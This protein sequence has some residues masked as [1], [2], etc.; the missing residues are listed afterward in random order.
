MLAAI[1]CKCLRCARL[2]EAV[3]QMRAASVCL[4]GPFPE[5][6]ATRG[7]RSSA[8]RRCSGGGWPGACVSGQVAISIASEAEGFAAQRLGASD[9]VATA[10]RQSGQLARTRAGSSR[11]H[12]SAHAAETNQVP[13]TG[14]SRPRRPARR[15][16]RH[17]GFVP[18]TVRAGWDLEPRTKKWRRGLTKAASQKKKWP[19]GQV[20]LSRS[21]TP[22]WE[23][24]VRNSVSSSF[25]ADARKPGTPREA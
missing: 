5:P 9:L 17:A 19:A 12:P 10:P 22:V 15:R 8:R 2:S 13:G 21:Q 16:P 14:A 4:S 23:R 11:E 7:S 3:P 18:K 20:T 24:N 6:S 25:W 1:S